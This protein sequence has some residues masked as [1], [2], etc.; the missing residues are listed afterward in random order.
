MT[1]RLLATMA[2]PLSYQ[3]SV[4]C[5]RAIGAAEEFR[6]LIVVWTMLF[7]AR[8]LVAGVVYSTSAS[9]RT[10]G[11][12][13]LPASTDVIGGACVACAMTMAP[14][15]MVVLTR[16]AA[17]AKRARFIVILQEKAKVAEII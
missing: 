3:V 2:P 6:T 10:G 14:A 15:Q 9:P 8:A 16:V 12:N 5:R 17:T 13:F 4:T 11:V 7:P 1:A